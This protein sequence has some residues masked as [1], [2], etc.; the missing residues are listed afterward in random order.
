MA[1]AGQ[2][3]CRL[4][5]TMLQ[6][7]PAMS[8]VERLQ[9]PFKSSSVSF[10]IKH[11]TISQGSGVF[12]HEKQGGWCPAAPEV[13]GSHAAKHPQH[14]ECPGVSCLWFAMMEDMTDEPLRATSSLETSCK[15]KW[16]VSQWNQPMNESIRCV[17]KSS[18]CFQGE[19]VLEN[20]SLIIEE[21]SLHTAAELLP[22]WCFPLRQPVVI[23]LSTDYRSGGGKWA[24]ASFLHSLVCPMEPSPG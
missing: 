17:Q 10:A 1:I 12:F 13:C 21:P 20:D 22:P 14:W 2:P 23:Q 8:A 24:V 6:S 9:C 4:W 5:G 19:G 18:C 16:I 3:Y 7:S 11:H 15:S